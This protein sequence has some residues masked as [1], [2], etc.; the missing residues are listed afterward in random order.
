MT[1]KYE[2]YAVHIRLIQ[3]VL[4]FEIVNIDYG[5]MDDDDDDDDDDDEF[6]AKTT[7]GMYLEV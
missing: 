4:S 1:S 6:F 2:F 7:I 5:R 3:C